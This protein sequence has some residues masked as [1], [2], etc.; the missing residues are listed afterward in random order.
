MRPFVFAV[1]V[2]VDVVPLMK[3]I[4]LVLDERGAATFAVANGDET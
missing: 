2:V 3:L 4:G 1:V